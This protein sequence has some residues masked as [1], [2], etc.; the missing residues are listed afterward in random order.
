[1][2]KDRSAARYRSLA[3]RVAYRWPVFAA[4]GTQINFWIITNVMLAVI[5]WTVMYAAQGTYGHVEPAPFVPICLMA[6]VV[7]MIYG[8]L[9]GLTDVWLDRHP[10]WQ[11]SLGRRILLRG[12]LYTIVFG[13][14]ALLTVRSFERVLLDTGI[15][16]L[17]REMTA[18]SRFRWVLTFVPTTLV[19]N[20]LVS[21]IRQTNRS[22]GPGLLVSLLLGRYREPVKEQRI[23][24]FMD[25]KGSTTHAEELGPERYSAMIRDLFHDVDSVVPRFEAEI[26]QYVGDEVVFTWNLPDLDDAR[27]C[28]F[29]F[30]AMQDAIAARRPY[31][32]KHYGRFPTFKAGVHVG[33]V[34]AVEIGEIKREIAYH[35]D[36]INTAARIQSMSNTFGEPLLVS[37]DLLQLCG[38]LRPLGLH[39]KALGPVTLRG[40]H[41]DLEIHAVQRLA[42]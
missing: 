6:A 37:G 8:S 30:F 19:G 5:N 4:M 3:V 18:E 7:G 1:M 28:L 38:D 9:L 34:I 13:F 24:F 20:F 33:E 17:P 40:K 16:D 2:A 12:V 32:E 42:P 29:F 26:H 36:P 10:K 31:Y 25:L 23:F 22:F 41:T 11:G 27:K 21:F 14:T 35:G 39:T 15:V